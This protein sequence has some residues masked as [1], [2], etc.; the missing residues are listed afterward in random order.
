[1]RGQ[2]N[3]QHKGKLMTLNTDEEML[4]HVLRMVSKTEKNADLALS[5]T[6]TIGSLIIRGHK[7]LAL[8]VIST[9]KPETEES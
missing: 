5:V 3:L 9:Y 8:Q 2:P 6:A 7:E 1:M 4:N